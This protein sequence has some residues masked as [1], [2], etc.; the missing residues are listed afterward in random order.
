VYNAGKFN[1]TMLE[2]VIKEIVKEEQEVKKK[3]E[4]AEKKAKEEELAAEGVVLEVKKGYG[5]LPYLL[6]LLPL[7]IILFNMFV[8]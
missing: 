2:W 4:A 6:L 3:Q 5:K 8:L 1:F 7:L